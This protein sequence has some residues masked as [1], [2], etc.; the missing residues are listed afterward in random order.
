MLEGALTP[1]SMT[2][3]CI[4]RKATAWTLNTFLLYMHHKVRIH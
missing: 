2:V 3:R 4:S 1:G